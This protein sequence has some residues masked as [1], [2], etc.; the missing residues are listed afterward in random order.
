MLGYSIKRV[1]LALLI[2]VVVMLGM[3]AMVYVIPGDP[4]SIALGPR[5]TPELKAL[6]IQRRYHR[7]KNG[8]GYYLGH[9]FLGDRRIARA[10]LAEASRIA[11]RVA[12]FMTLPLTE[13]DQ[14]S[15]DIDK[16]AKRPLQ[17]V[18]VFAVVA[19]VLGWL[20]TQ[21]KR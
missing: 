6:L 20:L 19:M 12:A 1:A 18:M 14:S 3:F 4:A 21:L 15:E 11:R 2:L 13:R 16:Q 5:A 17:L 10:K 9:I 8:D 7:P